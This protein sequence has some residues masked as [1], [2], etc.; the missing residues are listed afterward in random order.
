MEVIARGW[1]ADWLNAWLAALGFTWILDL[2]RLAWTGDH[3]PRAIL[4]VPDGGASVV[5]AL[6]AALPSAIDLDRL[7]TARLKQ[8]VGVDDYS[9]AASVAR[10]TGDRS[11]GLRV[12]DLGGKERDGD[13]KHNQFDFG[14]QQG[15]T[16]WAR[17]HECRNRLGEGEDLRAWIAGSLSGT[18]RRVQANGLGFDYRR[19]RAGNQPEA[20]LYVDPVIET[21]A[22]FGLM[23]FP[24]RGDGRNVWTRGWRGGSFH[25]FTW[26][27]GLD[28][29]GVDAVLG[30]RYSGLA[31]A[32]GGQEYTSILFNPGGSDANRGLASRRVP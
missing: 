26:R 22:F 13:L 19:L 10:R 3:V 27:S 1:T 32:E 6:A 15:I 2:G 18:G 20:K 25:W 12:T 23:F 31:V 28:R 29:W 11:L 21:L 5:E 24:V 30:A 16:I 8:H 9:R 14:A 17:V 7:A 4:T